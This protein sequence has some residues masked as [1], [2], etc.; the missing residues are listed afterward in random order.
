MD[1]VRRMG[2]VLDGH[3]GNIASALRQGPGATN[4]MLFSQDANGG[5]PAAAAAEP[6][7]NNQDPWSQ[8]AAAAGSP[9]PSAPAKQADARASY[10]P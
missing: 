5:Q 7:Q 6:W 1:S 2:H 4:P 10:H 3:T 9:A 8:G